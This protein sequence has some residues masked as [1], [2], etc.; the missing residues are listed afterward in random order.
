MFSEVATVLYN[1]HHPKTGVHT[2]MISKEVFDI[3]IANADV[4]I[5]LLV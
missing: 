5:Q 2:P 4:S 1:A 3:I